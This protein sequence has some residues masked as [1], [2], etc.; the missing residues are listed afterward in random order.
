MDYKEDLSKIISLIN[1]LNQ[2]IPEYNFRLTRGMCIEKFGNSMFSY[3]ENTLD[4]IDSYRYDYIRL[5]EIELLIDEIK[6]KKIQG[7]IAEVGVYKGEISSLLNR[8]LPE[9]KIYLFDTFVG[10]TD[11][12]LSDNTAH[13]YTNSSFFQSIEKFADTS[14]NVILRKMLT[15]ENCII[16]KG[17]FP[18]T[19]LNIK[20]DFCFVSIDVD[21]F[22]STLEALK[23]FYPKLLCG[24]YLFIHDYN[25][26]ELRGVKE[27]VYRYQDYINKEL[28]SVPLCDH[29]GTLVITK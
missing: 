2:K 19:A 4:N 8:L 26:D 24:G 18:Q 29:S 13:E 17:M 14:E 5:R 10:F 28:H 11:E 15:P 21:F 6:Y 16:C 20:E 25:D 1:D 12:L 27:A 9:K 3:L 22:V 23:Y 7:S